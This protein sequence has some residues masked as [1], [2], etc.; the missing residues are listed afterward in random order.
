VAE[1]DFRHE[2]FIDRGGT[3]TDFV[4]LDGATGALSTLKLPST[5]AAP[6]DGIRRLLGVAPGAAIPPCD[7]RLGTTVATNALLE[8]RGARTALAITRGFGDLLAIGD[9]TRPELFALAIQKSPPLAEAVLE[10]DARLDVTGAVLARPD[11]E[12]LRAELATL[13]ATGIDSLAIVVLHDQ[14]HGVLERE[15]AAL[16]RELGFG[17]VVCAHELTPEIGLLARAETTVLDAYLTPPLRTAL[18]RL[19]AELEGSRLRVLQSSGALSDPSALRG[20]AAL[21][22]GPAGGVVA[23]ARLAER[24][25]LGPVIGFDMGGTSTDVCR[26]AGPL[27]LDAETTVAGVRV[28]APVLAVTTI[29]AGGGSVCR[30]DGAKLTVGPESAGAI[31]GPLA[32]GRPEATELTLSDVNLLLGRLVPER[33]PLPLERQRAEQKLAAVTRELEA[34]GHS[35]SAEDVGAAFLEIGNRAMAA[36][37]REV[38]VSRG[39]DVREHTL[40]VLGGA[41]GQHA[42][43]VARLCG[44]SRIVFHPLGGVLAAVGVGLADL[45]GRRL[46]ELDEPLG[47]ASLARAESAFEELTRAGLAALE[48]QL[49][50]S[51]T[52]TVTRTLSLRCAGTETALELPPAPLDALV[53]NFHTLHRRLFGYDRSG[54][55]LELVSAHVELTA[56]RPFMDVPAPAPTASPRART[57]LYHDGRFLEDVPV[58]DRA[59]LEPGR[60]LEGPLVLAETTST[61]VIDPGF[62]VVLEP[63]GLLVATPIAVDTAGETLRTAGR[64]ASHASGSPDP[65]LLE[66]MGRRFM[67]IAEQMGRVLRRTALSTN[68][69]ERLDFSCAVFDAEGNLVANA[70]HIPVHLGAMGDSVR[71]VMARHPAL[72]PG[73]VFVTN[74]PALGGSHLPD[75]TV[76]APMFDPQG[77]LRFFVANRGHHA[78]VGGTAPGSMPPDSRRIEDEG[79]VLGALRL[80]HR[81]RFD[82]TEVLRALG[83]GPHPARRPADNLADL[84]AQVAAVHLGLELLGELGREAG[85]D[86][87]SRYMRHVA[88]DAA[89]RVRRFLARLP[90]GT[91]HF[92]DVLDDGTRVAATLTI[93]AD[94]LDVDFTGTSPEQPTNVNAPRA[95]TTAAVLYCLRAWLG[96]PIPLNA[97]CLRHVHVTVPQGCL[98]AP[99]PGAAVAAGNVETSQRIV[100]VLLGA[101]GIAAASQGTMNN[102]T[103]GTAAFGYYETIAGGAGAG[104]GFAGASAVHTHMTNTRLTDPEVLERRYP[105]RVRELSLRRGSGGGGRFP[106]GDGLCREL[107]L[108]APLRVSVISERRVRAPF[109]LDGGEPGKPGR[110]LVNGREQ[111][112]RFSRDLL[113]GDR[114]RIE[115]P[116]GGGY[117][118]LD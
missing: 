52:L 30:F 74:D 97:G 46:R 53:A 89:L 49:G 25:A 17:Y 20:S 87:V 50:S 116:G 47:P 100:D 101:A 115:T 21:L 69:R 5:E 77:T 9:Q 106:G 26:S 33:F 68:I 111:P 40:L 75:I 57:R 58:L 13:R 12:A 110:N 34:A 103:F 64:T 84:K 63:D 95:V 16:A 3:F 118:K 80:V 7:V 45:G 32:Y 108:L 70:P 107:E 104:P 105:V 37:I 36:A 51:D 29:A 99:H 91:R 24:A 39:H 82:E 2:I 83:S 43:A 59:S 109:G 113:P 23:C 14:R 54:H 15:V 66:V 93:E 55:T 4:H 90:P 85:F 8:R 28:R 117:G 27:E 112:G 11:P 38:S 79:I 22:S 19:G 10:L 41:G 6:L 65:M 35:L 48:P 67:S 98:L 76:V 56:R 60:S 62:R 114:V 92:E 78:D 81:G 42:C 72:E 71:G 44:M 61:V 102:L 73:D 96:E 31:P 94:R 1:R 18:S 88:D 86:T